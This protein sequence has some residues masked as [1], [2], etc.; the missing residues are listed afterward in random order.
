M[1]GLINNT[2]SLSLGLKNQS[3]FKVLFKQGHH[4]AF[5]MN[6]VTEDNC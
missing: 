3:V 5:P 2:H 6:E 4:H 1:I